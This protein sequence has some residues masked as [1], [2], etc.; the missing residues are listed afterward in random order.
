MTN[1]NETKIV[2]KIKKL[3]NCDLFLIFMPKNKFTHL[4]GKKKFIHHIKPTDRNKIKKF[5]LPA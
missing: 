4:E 3:K 2:L 5:Y 1:I